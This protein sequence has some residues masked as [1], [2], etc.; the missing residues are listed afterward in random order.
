MNRQEFM[1]Q[2]EYLLRGIPTS[3]REDALAYYNDYFDEAGLEN[4]Q[5]SDLKGEKVEIL[6]QDNEIEPYF[7]P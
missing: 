3:E 7:Q 5:D 6:S 2:L 4:G 1:K